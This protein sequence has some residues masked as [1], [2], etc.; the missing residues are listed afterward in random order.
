[1]VPT[2]MPRLQLAICIVLF[3]LVMLGV[4]LMLVPWLLVSYGWVGIAGLIALTFLYGF[5]VEA[6]KR[7]LNR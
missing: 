6:R 7:K 4:K 1:M 3:V 2:P 5:R